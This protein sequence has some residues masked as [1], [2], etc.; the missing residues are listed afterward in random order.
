MKVNITLDCTPQ[1]ARKFLGL[2]DVEPLQKAM[3]KQMQER[4]E[5][6][7]NMMDPETLL[8]QWAPIGLQS[9]EHFQRFMFDAARSMVDQAE[10]QENKRKV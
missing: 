6:A 7:M 5:N 8:K 4:T 9:L 2:P 10:D 1:E 3:L